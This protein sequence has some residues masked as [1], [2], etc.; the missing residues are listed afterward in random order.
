[1]AHATLENPP[2]HMGVP[3][4][5]GKLAMW[6]FMVTEIMFFTALIG[7][8]CL[9]R[10]STTKWPR[11]HDVHLVE[12]MGA[13]NTFV[14][15]CSSVSVVIAHWA[16][17]RNN[18]KL[19]VQLIA[20]TLLLGLVFLGIKAVE[21]TAKF[22]HGI[23]P[24][25]MFDRL[26]RDRGRAYLAAIQQ[27]LEEEKEVKSEADRMETKAT[28]FKAAQEE[29]QKDL[30]SEKKEIV[31]PS[32]KDMAEML[33]KK[34]SDLEEDPAW[35]LF[36]LRRKKAGEPGPTPE[37]L[38]KWVDGEHEKAEKKGDESHL[39]RAVRNG[40]LWASC[41][42]AMT[43][44]HALHVLGGLVIFSIILVMALRRKLGRRHD[45]MI[46]YTGLY[47]HFVD[48]VWIFLFPILYLV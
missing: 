24:G 7:T 30:P 8:C 4:R 16:I 29:K 2:L 41:Y 42:F 5:H 48:I 22:S 10:N 15:I 37:Q 13:L 9:L 14:L 38:A 1:M 19:T 11:P 28:E 12:W 25:R 33:G 39:T 40:N 35:I 23:I 44:F 17:S 36:Q 47:W 46:E 20:V 43:G 3:L 27:E 31:P 32:V 34:A 21:Y 45:G 6:F 26:E 18:V